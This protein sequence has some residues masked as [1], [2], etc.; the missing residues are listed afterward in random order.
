MLNNA[1]IQYKSQKMPEGWATVIDRQTL[2]SADVETVVYNTPKYKGTIHWYDDR[3]LYGSLC[4]SFTWEDKKLLANEGHKLFEVLHIPEDY[5]IR[6]GKDGW[7]KLLQKE[8]FEM[9]LQDLK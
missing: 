3:Y 9:W 8:Y 1:P 2:G 4:S 5:C 6:T 7:M